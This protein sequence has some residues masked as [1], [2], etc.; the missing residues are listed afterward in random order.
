MKVKLKI[1]SLSLA[2]LVS[3]RANAAADIFCEAGSF[4]K[5]Y[6]IVDQTVYQPRNAE[7]YTKVVVVNESGSTVFKTG[8]LDWVS[9]S[10]H[11]ESAHVLL[12][13]STAEADL[14]VG[15]TQWDSPNGCLRCRAPQYG[16]PEW[17]A[18]LILDGEL[19]KFT[20]TTAGF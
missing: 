14:T 8:K 18:N 13:N 7:E 3:N 15:Y 16:F 5:T 10:T 20:C 2:V 11:S 19:T 12:S 17:S 1:L 6:L 9:A 4:S